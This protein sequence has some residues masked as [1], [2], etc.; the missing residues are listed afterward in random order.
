MIVTAGQRFAYPPP[1]AAA[2][3]QKA[4]PPAEEQPRSTSRRNFLKWSALA[5]VAAAAASVPALTSREAA[6]PTPWSD[7]VKHYPVVIVGGGV[8]GIYAAWRLRGCDGSSPAAGQ[9]QHPQVAVFEKSIHIGGR[10]KSFKV[11]G[12]DRFAELGAMRYVPSRHYLV[13]TLVEDKLRLPTRE[14]AVSGPN[15]LAY[16]RGVRLT[17]EQI[18]KDPGVLPYNVAP[19]EKGKS[20][21]RLIEDAIH[22][23]IPEAGKLGEADWQRVRESGTVRNGLPLHKLG[24]QN[25]L[26]RGMSP[27]AYRMVTDTV[28]YDTVMQ[29]AESVSSIQEFVS[30]FSTD[31]TYRTLVNGMMDLPNQLAAQ[32]QQSGGQVYLQHEMQNLHYDAEQKRFVLQ[33]D[34]GGEST[35]VTADRVILA[36]PQRPLQALAEKS[37]LLN[38]PELRRLLDTVKSNPMTRIIA[39]YRSPW[40]REQGITQGRSITDLPLRQVYYYAGEKGQDGFLMVYNDGAHDEFWAGFQEPENPEAVKRFTATPAL[41]DELQEQ[42]GEMHGRSDLPAPEEVVYRRWASDS[43]GGAY[44]N[45]KP[46][47]RPWEASERMI[48]PLE[49]EEIPLYVCGEAFSQSQGWIQGALET[50]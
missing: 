9:L 30:D 28:G 23:V 12:T 2:G 43:Y 14:F 34:A 22:Q 48:Q 46:G 17:N 11:D 44:H 4:E 20:P 38:R 45:W 15:T 5:G 33:F 19:H 41:V 40:W 10:I 6:T 50:A 26:Y 29:N 31:T 27:E 35:T 21:G 16:L 39:R 24:F 47:T 13:R 25:V 3:G 18:E 36:L 32:F 49:S 42:L 1:L 8:S 7:N 37:P